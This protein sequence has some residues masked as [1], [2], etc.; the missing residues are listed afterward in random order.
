MRI[1]VVHNLP[2]GGARRALVEHCRGLRQ[3]GHVVEAFFPDTADEAFLSLEPVVDRVHVWR[4]PAP[5]SREP[6]LFAQ[7]GPTT[8]WAG[9]RLVAA[10][11]R[12][13]REMAA[14]VDRGGFEVVLASH[15][16]FTHAPS[17]LRH[18]ATPSAYFCQEPLRF[19]YEAPVGLAVRPSGSAAA[20]ALRT[21]AT[22][23]AKQVL[24]P[25]DAR[26][27][28]AARM[29]LANSVYS[30]E[31]ILRAYGRA[32]RVVYLGVDT[33]RFRPLG[34]DRSNVV[35]SV[36]ALHPTKGFDFVVASLG[37]IPAARRPALVI[38]ADRGYGAYRDLLEAQAR[39]CGVSLE[40]HT[41]VSEAELVRW[42]NRALL[43]AYAPYLEPFGLVVLEAMACGLPVVAVAEGGTRES[44]RPDETGVLTMRD[45]AAFADAI[46]RV[47]SDASLASRLA[48][49]AEVEV[50]R[51]WTW[52][53]SAEQLEA[54][55]VA[56]RAEPA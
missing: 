22:A 43:L 52:A 41:R 12:I 32:A 20:R 13:H 9:A 15:D 14:A 10:L 7:L 21:L 30:H 33:A 49:A 44:I 16:Q 34:L 56:C 3:R 23:A 42:Y 1:A 4:A 39:R 35:L 19:V 24:R 6:S 40:I 2:S 54:A 31:S 25:M 5:P 28:R 38:V 53:S 50:A 46:E 17:A 26:N 8:L 45:G 51:R 11:A 48:A 55:L 37:R 29:I 47:G 18:L 27:A 36:G